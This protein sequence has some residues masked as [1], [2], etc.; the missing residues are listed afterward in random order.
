VIRCCAARGDEEQDDENVAELCEKSSPR[1]YRTFGGQLIASNLGQ[2][3]GCLRGTEAATGIRVDRRGYLRHGES[4][5]LEH[6]ADHP[7]SA[8]RRRVPDVSGGT[9]AR[10]HVDARQHE[11]PLV[12]VRPGRVVLALTT[13]LGGCI[14]EQIDQLIGIVPCGSDTCGPRP[15]HAMYP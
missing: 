1:R 11:L 13:T 8:G 5:S 6:G 3:T 15:H 9:T 14:S 7:M 12:G 4:V 10:V 2:A